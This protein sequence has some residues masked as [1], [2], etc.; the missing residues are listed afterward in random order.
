MQAEVEFYFMRSWK[1]NSDAEDRYVCLHALVISMIITL[2][3]FSYLPL[4]HLPSSENSD[5]ENRYVYLHASVITTLVTFILLPYSHLVHLPSP[6][7][8]E[9]TKSTQH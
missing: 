9:Q 6:R 7:N 4:V 1:E 5:A 3:F 8:V 2:V